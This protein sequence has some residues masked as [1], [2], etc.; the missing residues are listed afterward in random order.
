M[1]FIITIFNTTIFEPLLNLLILILNV[2]PGHDLGIAIILLTL[3]TRF[4]LFPFSYKSALSQKRLMGLQ[5]KLKEL[6]ELHK[7]DRQT[8]AKAEM[9]L[10][11]E[12]NIN[13]FAQFLPFL[14]QLPIL[15][16]LY[17]VFLMEF[18]PQNINNLYSFVAQ[19][20][21]INTNFLGFINLGSPSIL[22]AVLAGLSQYAQS[23]LAF[24]Q[25]KNIGKESSGTGMDFQKIMSKQMTYI[26]PLFIMY[27][28]WKFPA[29]L[30]LYWV[31]TT[32]F[33]F[34]QQYVINRRV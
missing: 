32:L 6:R 14:I 17:R 34:A 16:G 13:L 23:K 2:M 18:I 26:F 7:N 25:K 1:G 10:Y 29:G 31:T 15:L 24:S 20:V 12:H 28:A 9:A 4:V 30:A 8:R 19:P 3:A 5:P 21:F 22:L 11:K 27:I 33:S